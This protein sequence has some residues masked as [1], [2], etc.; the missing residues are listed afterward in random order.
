MILERLNTSEEARK[1]RA[2]L[3]GRAAELVPLLDKNAKRTED[4]RRIAGENIAAIEQAELFKM[5]Q[6]RRFGGLEVEFRT[7]LEVTRELGP[8]LRFDL[9]DDQFDQHRRL[10]R[11]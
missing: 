10:R 1:L 6:P 9:V 3:V 7:T 2:D 8:R 4:D 11:R 5:M